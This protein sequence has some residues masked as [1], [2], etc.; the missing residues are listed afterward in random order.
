MHT[1]ALLLHLL[2]HQVA[3]AGPSLRPGALPFK[4]PAVEAAVDI[5]KTTHV[6]GFPLRLGAYRTALS[7]DEVMLHFTKAFAAAGFFF[8]PRTR[9]PGL[10]LP[11]VSALDPTRRVSYLVYGWP[12]PNHQSTFIIGAASFQRVAP[13]APENL[14]LVAPKA[15]QVTQFDFESTHAVCFRTA[16]SQAELMQHYRSILPK[17]GWKESTPGVFQ[18]QGRQLRILAKDEGNERSVV[19]WNEGA[20]SVNSIPDSGLL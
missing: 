2:V 7:T 12:E 9:I 17:A 18:R 14:S 16:L 13:P 3:D 6:N 19:V 4:L 8:P 5:G 15:F 1:L 11:H 10:T 20:D